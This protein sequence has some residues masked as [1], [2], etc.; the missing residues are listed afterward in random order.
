MDLGGLGGE[1]VG[2]EGRG[3]GGA[4][5]LLGDLVFFNQESGIHFCVLGAVAGQ[6]PSEPTV[7]ALEAL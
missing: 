4:G 7:R 6:E 3:G 1:T 2:T 5:R